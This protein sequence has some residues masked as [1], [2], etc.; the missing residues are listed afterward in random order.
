MHAWID[1]LSDEEKQALLSGFGEAKFAP[2]ES[3]ESAREKIRK[4]GYKED[5]V[6]EEYLTYMLSQAMSIGKVPVVQK[7]MSG[8]GNTI[9]DNILKN[10]DYNVEQE[11]ERRVQSR[12]DR[13]RESN[14]GDAGERAGVR[15][16][17]DERGREEGEVRFAVANRNQEIF[18]SNAERAAES[19]KMDK[20]TPTQWIAML[21]KAG[22]LKSG[23]DKWLGL[24]DWLKASDKKT[25]TKQEILEFI[26]QNRILIEET[27]YSEESADDYQQAVESYQDE[28]AKFVEEGV[29]QNE[30]SPYEYAFD[31][32]IDRYGDDFDLAFERDGDSISPIESWDGNGLTKAAGYFIEERKKN[33]DKFIDP[34]RLDYTTEGLDNKREIALTVPTIEPWNEGDNIHFGDAGEGRAI[35]W[36]RF[37]ETV[38]RTVEDV[39]RAIEYERY[40]TEIGKVWASAKTKLDRGV[41]G[42]TKQQAE[43]DLISSEQKLEKLEKDF[44][45]VAGKRGRVLVIDE[46]QSKRHQTAREKDAL[47]NEIGYKDKELEEKA[48]RHS[49]LSRKSNS[50][51]GLTFEEHKEFRQLQEELYNVGSYNIERNRKAVPAAPFE[52]NWHE[53]AMK[54]M[55]RLAAEEGYDYVAWTTGAQ[56]AERYNLNKMVSEIAARAD[57]NGNYYVVIEDKQGFELDEFRGSGKKMTPNE[58]VSYFGKDLAIRLMTGADQSRGKE[59]SGKGN[60]PEF[61]TVRGDD[62][63]V[64]GEGMKG[65]YDDILVRFVN[66][67]AKKWGVQVKDIVLPALMGSAKTMHAIPVTQEMKD[68]VMEGQVMF[69]VRAAAD[70]RRDGIGAV[71][72]GENVSDFYMTI[73][74][75]MTPEMRKDVVE[76][77]MGSSL[78]FVD[79]LQEYVS[80]VA[81][82]GYQNDDTGILLVAEN[83]LNYYS[84]ETINPYAAQYILWRGNRGVNEDDILDVAH[85]QFMWNYL[86]VEDYP[87]NPDD[88]PD[89]PGKGSIEAA[90][91]ETDTNPSDAQKEAGN[92]KHGHVSI[93]GYNISLENPKGSVRSGKDA[94]GNEWSVT[95]NNDYGYIRM[96]EG[97]DGDH[98]DVFL[99]DNPEQGNV[100]VV[101]Q[102]DPKSGEF[103]EHKVMYGFNSEDE[104]REAYLANYSEG[105]KGLGAITGVTKDEFKKWIESSHRKTK[106]FADYKSV[107]F[108][109]SESMNEADKAAESAIDEA[110][111]RLKQDKKDLKDIL[112]AAKA[113]ALQ[114]TY[115]ESTVETVTNLAKRILKDQF[116]D[117]LSRRE[118]A[119]L[120][121]IVR[122]SVGKSPKTVKKNADAIVEM[123]ID[124]LLKR[125]KQGLESMLKTTGTKTNATGVEVQAEL[126][127]QGQKTLKAFKEGLKQEI[128]TPED[129]ETMSTLYGLRARLADRLS[130]KDDA[131]R[132]DAE[133]EDAGLALA[134]DYKENVKSLLD[135]ED[136]LLS[137]L[138]DLAAALKDGDIS[139][140]NYNESVRA[141]EDS[142]RENH[143]EQ[144]DAH[145]DF[146]HKLQEMLSGSADARRAFMD[147]EKARIE[148][149]HHLANS[150]MQGR[151][152]D[153]EKKP[154]F[155]D[156]L[157]NSP[158]TRFFMAPLQTFDQMLRLFGGKSIDGR[159]YLWNKYMTGW[160]E[161]TEKAYIGQ[162]DAKKRLDEKASEVF[163][164]GKKWAD[165]FDEERRMPTV[166]VKWRGAD[167]EMKEH[168]LTQGQ[169][170]YI[171]MVNKMADGRMKLRRMGIEEED[172][173]AIRRVLDDRFVEIADWLQEEFLVDLRNKY[174]AVHERLF[175]ASMAAIENYFPLVINKRDINRN[176]DIAALDYESLPSTTTGSIIKR[177]RNSKA[178]DLLN[179]DAFSVILNHI[180]QMEQW[181]AFAEFNK[182]VNA[183]LSY[184]RFRNQ[185]QNMA[186]VYGSG[187]E[188]WKNFKDVAR[189]AGNAYHPDIKRSSLDTAAVNLAKGVTSAKISF[190]VYT[191]IKQLL[192]MPAFISDANVARLAANMANPIGAWKWAMNNLPLFEKRWSSRIAG[193]TRLM[194]T[195]MDW[196]VFRSKVY[197]KLSKLGMTP[198]A[199]VDAV[200]VA[201][202]AHAIYQTKYNQYVKEGFSE[203]QADKKAKQDATV[204]YNETQQSNEN[205]FLSPVQLDRT[206]FATAITVFRNSSMGFQRQLHDAVRNLG[207]M[208]TPGYKNTSVEFMTKQLE[209]E[210]LSPEQA[211]DAAE[212]RYGKAFARNA[213]RAATFGFLVQFAWNLGGSLAYLLL[214]DDDDEKEEM[215]REAFVHALIGG[216]IEGLAGGNVLSEAINMVAKGENLT[217]YDPTLLPVLSDMKRIYSMMS[218]DNVAAWNEVFNLATQALVGVNPQ[219]FE[220]AVVAI[221]DA[222]EGDPEISRE[223]MLLIMRVMQVPQSQID[224]VYIDELGMSAENARRLSPQQM[225]KRYARYKLMRNAGE[226]TP[227]YS[228]EQREKRLKT[229]EKSFNKKVKERKELKKK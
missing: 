196:K 129:D 176:E 174:N 13:V 229:Y 50:D 225:A 171:Y 162:R 208:L 102:V 30:P 98:I 45:D 63:Q 224:K 20:A 77:T 123:V 128:G 58:M 31:M 170:L 190:R 15:N 17:L 59:W 185:V 100:Y 1:K 41:T 21:E 97:T 213:V 184:K 120:L 216:P 137:E 167:G 183:L 71:I 173:Q 117:A 178:L 107:R 11:T 180:D 221:I 54:R 93:D 36:A 181:A 23:E 24:S 127:V 118:V 192:S 227:V 149:I 64:G 182:D 226:W 139:K 91:E 177:R 18:V 144:V 207:K 228:D 26:D 157:A 105:W 4:M 101:D 142:L 69:S 56:Q 113:M 135:E 132:K 191:A 85:D 60:N 197:D 9:L 80:N 22:G 25:I 5:D 88:T 84:D 67:Y 62:L 130:S 159:G 32:M 200:T 37:G 219:T 76:K 122:T 38:G 70:A 138:K 145:R 133:A 39:E 115:D 8:D 195:D 66:K 89:G 125:E 124:N 143:I 146:R 215:L 75:A 43:L 199:F 65:F 166:T 140:S 202:G 28:Y 68:S 49:E 92:Y 158:V 163:G 33:S 83:L 79:A 134:I 52:K 150:D 147:R 203:E 7:S 220:D 40:K 106:P 152:A 103:D 42:R 81:A 172:V 223:A 53:L 217:K 198:N 96:T 57:G 126:D 218:Y 94:S 189:I 48:N 210:G 114:K 201:V 99:S 112:T 55:L 154:T 148:S 111:E 222:C 131:T 74:G 3:R 211:K 116:V 51:E 47:G 104:A 164:E 209:R 194:T 188:L 16:A 10:I 153:T 204:L 205:A 206:L 6:P 46:I 73:Y 90:R 175:G 14:A 168:E 186:S 2:E 119:R 165:I 151:S 19:I 34:T 179:A 169:M 86:K 29:E 72:G 109:V 44:G 187:T 61:F 212:K 78:N 95:M 161:A 141:T 82:K 87:D 155:M 214:G 35:A 121:G 12:A 156:K 110:Q 136:D 160:Q 108:S 193:D 27:H